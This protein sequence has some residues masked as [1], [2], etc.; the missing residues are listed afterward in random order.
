MDK[1]RDERQEAQGALRVFSYHPPVQ[2]A[3]DH[4]WHNIKK[5]VRVG[6]TDMHAHLN[7]QQITRESR[8]RD[9]RQGTE[10]SRA[11]KR[12]KYAHYLVLGK[13]KERNIGTRDCKN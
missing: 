3:Y 1:V 12:N 7:A 9:V 2:Y 8:K 11:Q 13:P 6:K 5:V 4:K 10:E